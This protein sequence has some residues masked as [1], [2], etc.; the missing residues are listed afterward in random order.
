MNIF[1]NI[2][3]LL[4]SVVMLQS[5]KPHYIRN[6]FV[7]TGFEIRAAGNPKNV[8]ILRCHVNYFSDS[9]FSNLWGGGI[10]KGQNGSPHVIR[11]LGKPNEGMTMQYDDRFM[12]IDSF[13]A[14]YNTGRKP[15]AGQQIEDEFALSFPYELETESTGIIMVL[16]DKL[17]GK[18]DTL[19]SSIR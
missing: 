9:T 10:E 12:S 5:C 17:T 7:V 18:M 11:F 8:G 19:K 16:Q 4:L 3:F 6:K 2:P 15:C 14:L 13:I 1:K